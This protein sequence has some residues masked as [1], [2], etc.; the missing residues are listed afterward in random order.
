MEIIF[1]YPA[2]FIVF[3]ALL[4]LVYTG[5][6][7]YKSA[8]FSDDS[9]N[10]YW[11]KR[12][13]ALLRFLSGS[14]L[15]FLLLS[16]FIKSK[17]V[18]RIDPVIVFVHDN[19]ES[20]L[21]NLNPEDSVKYINSTN[22]MLAN[23]ASKYQI[24]YYT[25][26]ES[27]KEIDT[28]NFKGKSTNISYALDQINGLYFNQNVG[29]VILASD[30]IYNQGNNPIYSEFNF[31][32]YTVALG[33][34]NQ[35][36]DA[37]IVN[38]RAN[39]LAY[40]DDKVQVEIDLQA[41]HLQ[42]KQYQLSIKSKN[43]VLFNKTL[44]ITKD[45]DEQKT[46]FTLDARTVGIHRYIIQIQEF[47]DEISIA[48]NSFEI[49]LEVIDNR[50]KILLI[51]NAPHPDIAAIKSVIEV[52]KNFE[53]SIQYAQKLQA[54]LDDYSLIIA[55]QIPSKNLGAKN[56]LNNIKASKIPVWFITGSGSDYGLLNQEQN[57][58][59]ISTQGKNGNDASTYFNTSFSAFS[60]SEKTIENLRKL[61]PLKTPFGNYNLSPG[62]SILLQQKIGTVQTDFP[63]LAFQESLGF[64]SAILVGDG[65]WRWK[66]YDFLENNNNEV[67]NEIIEKTINYL[68]LKGDKRKFR[69]KTNKTAYYDGEFVKFEAELYNDNYELLNSPEVSL[70]LL[71]EDG[72]AYPFN[73]NKTDKAYEFE[74]NSLPIGTYRYTANTVFNGKELEVSGAFSISAMQ[75]EALQ[76]Q[77]NHNLLKQLANKTSGE[78]ISIE[79][80]EN[81]DDLL[82][83]KES[84]KPT[85]YESF[86]TRPIINL[87]GIFFIIMMLL[88]LEWFARKW[89]GSY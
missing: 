75:L 86:K 43:G 14:L 82:L 7:Y 32:L 46:N 53:I 37:K 55:H 51:A 64:R 9:E 63:I 23:L 83:A 10:F 38:V 85:L 27:M 68:A 77:A 88:S 30:G 47:K 58:V 17:F 49:Y 48:N 84:I 54:N 74:T 1:Q 29:A 26:D 8:H 31:P 76:T 81:L 42:G 62:T 21:V 41:N 72:T 4:G 36:T 89:F 16:P 11:I 19:S 24:D 56:I 67:F 40:L 44:V 80:L 39:K 78:F 60:L 25:F 18:D 61:P 66:L 87:F 79:A 70:L 12:G 50:Q 35:Q 15:A 6:L 22:E 65:L 59:Q 2:W 28:L 73:F 20:I 13:L 52:N 45:F 71:N 69:A 3:C 34:T 57:I 33:D 5:V